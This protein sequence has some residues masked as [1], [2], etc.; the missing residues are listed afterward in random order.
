M[1][2]VP[3]STSRI[4]TGS[5]LIGRAL[6]MEGVTNVF[7]LAGR[8]RPARHGRDGGHG[9][10]VHRHAAR[11]GGGPHGR[12]V[13][14]A[15]PGGP[16]VAMYTTPGFAN[17]IPGLSSALNS[18]APL[19]SISGCAPLHELGRGAMQEIEQGGHG[20]TDDQ[21]RVAGHRPAPHPAHD[22]PGAEARL[23]REARPRAPDHPHR[24]TAADP[25]RERGRLLRAVRV[26]ARP[27]LRRI[28][29]AG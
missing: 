1:P 15:S 2:E 23:L 28:R 11:A 12:R 3:L 17:A 6:R 10:P 20:A 14:R 9:L 27:R 4:V 19:L 22:R 29:R 8:P 7:A 5:H 16:G 25:G 13:G 18:E 21:G 24:R 26:P